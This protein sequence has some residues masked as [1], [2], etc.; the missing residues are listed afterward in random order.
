MG[1]EH[2][3]PEVTEED[4]EEPPPLFSSWNTWYWVVF[5]NLVAL[6]VL[7]TIFTQVFS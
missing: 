3:D 5:M 1:V 4:H 7:F 2:Q 6:I